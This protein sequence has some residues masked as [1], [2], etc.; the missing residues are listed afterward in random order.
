MFFDGGNQQ[1]YVIDRVSTAGRNLRRV[2]V[3]SDSTIQICKLDGLVTRMINVDTITHM[4]FGA[5]NGIRGGI[6]L[7]RVEGEQD[8]MFLH[9][10]GVS[11]TVARQALTLLDKLAE[12]RSNA[13]AHAP[14]TIVERNDEALI[15]N[16]ADVASRGHPKPRGFPVAEQLLVPILFDDLTIPGD[17]PLVGEELDLFVDATFI[18][19]LLRA[20][21]QHPISAMQQP[22]V[23]VDTPPPFRS[24]DISARFF[25]GF[26]QAYD[27]TLG[28]VVNVHSHLPSITSFRASKPF[29][30]FVQRLLQV[31]R[32]IE[33]AMTS[34]ASE[35]VEAYVVGEES[36]S[37]TCTM[38]EWNDA[39]IQ[40]E[41]RVRSPEK[42]QL[43]GSLF[44][45]A[46]G[47]DRFW[48]TFASELESGQR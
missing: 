13:V 36:Y 38:K 35:H 8:L 31:S 39:M 1:T 17:G 48:Q 32:P 33:S 18:N 5:A 15:R 30:V 20:V 46:K 22:R 26:C 42:K 11:P 23:T 44:H 29:W 7:L 3:L 37:V 16:A 10:P 43:G 41:L 27:T 25:S 21:D 4:I 6:V 24:L 47:A 12:L 28:L 9:P 19:M 14:L 45:F 34:L 2:L 40:W